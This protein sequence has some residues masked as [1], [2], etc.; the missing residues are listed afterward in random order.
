MIEVTESLGEF[1]II[2]GPKTIF[3]SK[4]GADIKKYIDEH[5][6]TYYI[7]TIKWQDDLV[8]VK[9]PDP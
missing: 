6:G 8:N 4:S 7:R 5:E 2:D 3:K 9:E 1:C